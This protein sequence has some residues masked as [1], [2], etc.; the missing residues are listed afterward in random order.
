[1]SALLVVR[2]RAHGTRIAVRISDSWIAV[3]SL[4]MLSVA[5]PLSGL[6]GFM[7]RGIKINRKMDSGKGVDD[8]DT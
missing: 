2:L 6:N 7:H 5:G 1:M 3:I 4:L 8:E